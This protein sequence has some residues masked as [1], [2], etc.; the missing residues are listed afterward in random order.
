MVSSQ[1]SAKIAVITRTKDRPVL[2]RRA[3]TSVLAQTET[4]WIHVI[5]NDGG[6]A[7][8]VEKLAA[9]F[10]TEY[11]GRLSLIH[12]DKS[13]G[14]EAASNVG[15]QNS[16]SELI[17]IHDDDDTWDPVFLTTCQ[18]ALAAS[19]LP[20]ACAVVTRTVRIEEKIEDGQIR[21]IKREPYNEGMTSV[22]IPRLCANNIFPPISLLFQRRL[23]DE[24]GGFDESLPVLGDWDFNLRMALA[25]EILVVP[26]ALAFYHHRIDANGT[27]AN[28]IDRH[29]FYRSRLINKWAREEY[30]QGRFSIA[31]AMATAELNR[32]MHT[33]SRR[34][35]DWIKKCCALWS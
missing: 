17:A 4:N 22:E 25:G 31:Q 33:F 27:Y 5:V 14:M 13:L 28:T 10:Q 11:R 18:N 26:E 19:P 21:E 35:N 16:A 24:V 2:L 8:Q 23:I 34:M 20:S 12:H 32:E 7:D 6:N 9:E 30:A 15:I 3:I 29:A 1:P